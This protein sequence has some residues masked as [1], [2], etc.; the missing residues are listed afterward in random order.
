MCLDAACRLQPSPWIRTL[1]CV[2]IRDSRRRSSSRVGC[3]STVNNFESCFNEPSATSPSAGNSEVAVCNKTVA[4]GNTEVD[5]G[6]REHPAQQ[7]TE[8][9]QAATHPLPPA[10]SR[11]LVATPR[12]QVATWWL[13][14]QQHRP[15]QP[16]QPIGC[17][18]QHCGCG[19]QHGGCRS[20]RGT[21]AAILSSCNLFRTSSYAPPEFYFPGPRQISPRSAN[22]RQ[23]LSATIR[24][25]STRMSTSCSASRR[26][27][28]M[29]S[30]A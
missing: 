26:R 14:V 4:D 10:T 28:V 15:P 17:S 22:E 11:L 24:W 12:L 16:C 29:S 7:S 18:W 13:T 1:H 9:L 2:G 3:E 6:T 8:R 30:S 20:F 23:P 25:S 19:L 27:R 5:A 21:R